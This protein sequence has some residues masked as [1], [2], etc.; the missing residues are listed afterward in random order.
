MA[1]KN[2]N[3]VPLVSVDYMMKTVFDI[4]VDPDDTGDLFGMLM[5]AAVKQAA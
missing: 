3:I 5:R 4:D 2:L 1:L